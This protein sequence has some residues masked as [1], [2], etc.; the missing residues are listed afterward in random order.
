[1]APDAHS[2][3]GSTP[4]IEQRSRRLCLAA[5][6]SSLILVLSAAPTPR[7]SDLPFLVL[8]LTPYPLLGWLAWRARR[9]RESSRLVFAATLL[10]AL[11]GVTLLALDCLR[12][13]TVPE[14]R[15]VQRVTPLVVPSLQLLAVGVIG[16]LVELQRLFGA[17]QAPDEAKRSARH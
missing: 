13:H 15:L 8:V 2:A 5:A 7:F 6:T 9:K 14:H 10:L 11:A 3:P 16:L 1:M 4:P 12:F 17:N